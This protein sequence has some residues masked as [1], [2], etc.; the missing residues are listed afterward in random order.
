MGGGAWKACPCVR[1]SLSC[2]RD[3]A[4]CSAH[5]QPPSAARNRTESPR[6]GVQSMALQLPESLCHTISAI[7]PSLVANAGERVKRVGALRATGR[8]SAPLFPC[9]HRSLHV[10]ATPDHRTQS[11]PDT[12][13]IGP[14]PIS[15]ALLGAAAEAQ[16]RLQEA[17][18]HF[19]FL[20]TDYAR[21]RKL[22]W[23]SRSCSLLLFRGN[24]PPAFGPDP[25]QIH[26]A[27][28]YTDVA[29]CLRIVA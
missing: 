7:R 24:A 27:R 1:A 29:E 8:L 3:G 4:A 23:V 15:N 14:R 26:S 21:V 10:Q 12:L 25:R 6:R 9:P 22:T 19:E 5:R 20:R 11:A 18:R 2:V 13:F 16:Q 28:N 17:S